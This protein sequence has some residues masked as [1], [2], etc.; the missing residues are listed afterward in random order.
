MNKSAERFTVLGIEVNPYNPDLSGVA[1]MEL[2]SANSEWVITRYE[3][4]MMDLPKFQSCNTQT[5]KKQSIITAKRLL[6]VIYKSNVDVVCM[7]GPLTWRRSRNSRNQ[8]LKRPGREC[9]KVN[10][11]G[12][13]VHGI[14]EFAKNTSEKLKALAKYRIFIAEKLY[15]S[16]FGIKRL[17]ESID[18]S[19]QN[20]AFKIIEGVMFTKNSS[21]NFTLSHLGAMCP[22]LEPLDSLTKGQLVAANRCLI[23][24]SVCTKRFSIFSVGLPLLVDR[25]SSDSSPHFAE[26]YS[27]KL[28]PMFSLQHTPSPLQIESMSLDGFGPY[29]KKQKMSFAPLTIICGCNGKGKSTWLDA[30]ETLKGPAEHYLNQHRPSQQLMPFKASIMESVLNPYDHINA[31]R[32]EEYFDNKG[33]AGTPRGRVEVVFKVTQNIDLTN[34]PKLFQKLPID[35][36]VIDNLINKQFVRKKSNLTLKTYIL[37]PKVHG[38]FTFRHLEDLSSE[39][40]IFLNGR[41][42]VCFNYKCKIIK[43]K[44]GSVSTGAPSVKEV[45]EQDG[46]SVIPGSWIDKS[47]PS[48]INDDRA[49][50]I[51]NRNDGSITSSGKNKKDLINIASYLYALWKVMIFMGMKG[52]FHIAANRGKWEKWGEKNDD[53]TTALN[54]KLMLTNLLRNRF[55]DRDGSATPF[56]LNCFRRN[57][58]VFNKTPPICGRTWKATDLVPS[59]RI[60]YN[61]L[62]NKDEFEPFIKYCIRIDSG[63]ASQ[64]DSYLWSHFS[65]KTQTTLIRIVRKLQE[66]EQTK[67][68][69]KDLPPISLT[70]TNE[71]AIE[72]EYANERE[73]RAKYKKSII[74]YF[75]SLQNTLTAA[76]DHLAEHASLWSHVQIPPSAITD[77]ILHYEKEGLHPK[78]KRYLNLLAVQ[79]ILELQN[80]PLAD[81]FEYAMSVYTQDLL[82]VD[83]SKHSKTNRTTDSDDIRER[84][85]F[86]HTSVIP[87]NITLKN[88]DRKSARYSNQQHGLLTFSNQYFQTLSYH[89]FDDQKSWT[90]SHVD[91]K[92]YASSG[93]KQI[94]PILTQTLLMHK[95]EML[96]I[97]NPEVHLHPGLQINLMEFLI[98]CARSGR[99]ILMETHSDLI[100]KRVM[101][102]IAEG[103]MQPDDVNIYFVESVTLKATGEKPAVTYPR[104]RK[105]K[106][107]LTGKMAVKWPKGFMDDAVRESGKFVAATLRKRGDK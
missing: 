14:G 38:E 104:L 29:Y 67:S 13:R 83:I 48:R 5:V 47:I 26:G 63:G 30:L 95:Y 98:K 9:D 96:A 105:V 10:S 40:A 84:I 2:H 39:S 41:E 107:D 17:T 106:L 44:I 102:A 15:L 97:E 37:P 90:P 80:N 50:A 92:R 78:D 46:W 1:L 79:S 66:L 59:A 49:I 101:R 28:S 27:Y 55:V 81:G 12:I 99:R 25:E 85:P 54:K 7:G 11:V 24:S 4:N 52:Y 60:Y 70:G 8:K 33:D 6:D 32:Y 42:I 65:K 62:S 35:I 69:M 86:C 3:A 74:K 77:S 72:D 34:L 57:T 21:K 68:E 43:K 76:F 56:L 88:N 103:C 93:V 75:R 58:D 71:R 82:G 16:S 45:V 18:P 31:T 73:M 94:L 22:E 23:A 64:E 36:K 100:V 91:L 19:N 53:N 61:E 87:W 51:I 89:I 20:A